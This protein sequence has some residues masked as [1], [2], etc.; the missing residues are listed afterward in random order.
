MADLSVEFAGIKFK[1]PILAASA[2]PT[3][4]VRNIRR[5][6]EA[7]AGGLVAKSVSN[8]PGLRKMF[9]R[10]RILNEKHEIAK[11]KVPR[12]FTLYGRGGATEL[13]LEEWIPV[14]KEA[15]RIADS[16]GA[17]LIGSADGPDIQ[18]WV[19]QAKQMEDIGI[20]M[21]E[22]NFGCPHPGSEEAGHKRVAQ[23]GQDIELSSEIVRATKKAISI[24]LVIKCTPQVVDLVEMARAMKEAGAAGI[25][26]SNRFLGFVVDIHTGK[27]L[28]S[29]YAGVGGPWVKPITSRWVSQVY[30]AMPDFPVSASNGAYDWKDAVEFMMAG[31]S[32]VQLCSAL[33]VKGIDYISKVIKGLNDFLDSKDYKRVR[34]I[35]GIAT[36]SVLPPSEIVNLPRVRAMV[37][38]EKCTLC[39]NCVKSCMF[40]AIQAK[41]E[42][43]WVDDEFCVGCE[44]CFSLCP[45]DAIA[46]VAAESG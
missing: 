36:M 3:L 2:E 44:L 35:T 46:F 13:T 23:I 10:W 22:F 31:A 17:V 8:D 43:V 45:V 32:S 30:A 38:I 4:T 40:S 34:D 21:I 27:P 39:G 29:G 19:D 7:G 28:L 12:A 25:T 15:R 41:D 20:Q 1:N 5:V 11:G 26:I 9:H 37:D 16:E 6:I 18:S 24:P 33:L 42:I 14:L